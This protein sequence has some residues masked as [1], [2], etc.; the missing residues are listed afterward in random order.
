MWVLSTL[1][2]GCLPAARSTLGGPL[3]VCVDFENGL[4]TQYNNMLEQGLATVKTSLPDYDLRF[5]DVYTPMLRLIQNPFQSG[6]ILLYSLT[7]P[8]NYFILLELYI[9]AY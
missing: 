3:R 6:L 1:P 7:N 4:A 5:V 8:I 2:L 9:C